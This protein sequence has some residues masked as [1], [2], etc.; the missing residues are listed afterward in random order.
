[1]RNAFNDVYRIQ[2][3]LDQLFIKLRPVLDGPELAQLLINLQEAI[4]LWSLLEHTNISSYF[5][6]AAA[7][8]SHEQRIAWRYPQLYE[9]YLQDTELDPELIQFILKKIS[10]LLAPVFLLK[11]SLLKHRYKK[12]A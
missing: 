5:D 1:M 3:N 9:D 4:K 12:L 11:Q 2:S 6:Q 7:V 8:P 10:I